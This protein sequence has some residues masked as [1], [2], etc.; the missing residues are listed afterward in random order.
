MQVYNTAGLADAVHAEH[1]GADVDALDARVGSDQGTNRAAAERV[2]SHDKL[3]NRDSAPVSDRF[4]DRLANG[5]GSIAEVSV[6]LDHDSLVDAGHMLT[7]M[8]ASK[9]G[10]HCVGHIG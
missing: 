4:E 10:V 9:V 7:V 1:W 6:D 8:L 2:V 3:L 5:V